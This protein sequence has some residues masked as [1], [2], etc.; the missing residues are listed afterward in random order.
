MERCY[1][2]FE[3]VI[4]HVMYNHVWWSRVAARGLVFGYI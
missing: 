3:A 4:G 2:E 1:L